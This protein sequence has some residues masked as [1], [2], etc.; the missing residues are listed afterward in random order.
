[1]A[2]DDKKFFMPPAVFAPGYFWFL[3]D[4]LD[5]DKLVAQLEDMAKSGARSVCPHPIPKEFRA[6][7]Y[8]TM[9]PAYLSKAFFR[10]MRLI[11]DTCERLKMNCYLY[12]EGGWPSG[13]ACGQVY[14]ANPEKFA[15]RYLVPD[16][17]GRYKILV[18]APDPAMS[19]PY[20]NLLTPG[21]TEKFLA[22]THQ[23]YFK[24]SPKHFGKTLCFTF[25][26]EPAGPQ[27][28]IDKLPWT[29]DFF[30]E[31]KKRKN[32]DVEPFIPEMLRFSCAP[33]IIAALT[34]Y[35]DVVSQ[36]FVERFLA[37][38][39]KWCNAHQM[40]SGGH[41]NGEDEPQNMLFHLHGNHLLRVLRQLDMPGVDVIWRQIYPGIRLHSFPKY[42]SSAANQTGNRHVLGEVFGV[43]GSGITPAEMK[44]LVDY[45]AL[46]GVNTFVFATYPF[47][48]CGD[49]IQGE[50][51][52]FG[53]CNL[54]WRRLKGFH[55]YT[56][57]ISYLAAAGNP[58]VD[59]A[60]FFDEATLSEIGVV[61]RYDEMENIAARLL[62]RQCDFDYIDEDQLLAAKVSRG[63]IKI[64]KAVYCRIVMPT[65]AK[66]TAKGRAALEKLQK[67][68]A[69]VFSS[70]QINEIP[71]TLLMAQ[72]DDRLRVRKRKLAGGDV[73]YM[74]MN[75]SSATLRVR[76]TASEKAPVAWCDAETGKRCL[77]GKAGVWQ[78]RFAPYENAVFLVGEAA[79]NAAKLPHRPGATLR[80]LAGKWQLKALRQT[81]VG[82]DDYENKKSNGSITTVSLGDWRNSLGND[83]SGEAQYVKTFDGKD[84][85]NAKFLDLGRVCYAA[86]VTLNGVDLGTRLSPPYVFPLGN[87]L[88]ATQNKLEITVVNTPANA[89]AATGV[90]EKW[91]QRPFENPYEMRERYF[92]RESLESGL[93]G[94]VV[95]KKSIRS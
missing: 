52:L 86:Q 26:D 14:A 25:T 94:P 10:K 23:Q 69:P 3:N 18:D 71:P 92:E 5:D 41:F 58:A 60:L 84:L 46:C 19:A 31:F 11:H 47:S 29:E 63:A 82:K 53:K 22:L 91:Q 48:T 95:F 15:R 38:L 88:K 73:L 21:V 43:Y 81:S 79:K 89:I 70:D 83:F 51:P 55:D 39:K 77:A 32:Y 8:S 7:F 67:K 28:R 12:D 64:G 50:R 80:A 20:P 85:A 6:S 2:F 4:K 40:L 36:L 1:M 54:L 37:P 74:V 44:F 33:Q 34:D 66:L 13:G 78:W 93:F 62:Q 30:T 17:Q 68:G 49:K 59:T 24:Y 35:S 76:F 42:A 65:A 75:I 27:H 90:L 45:L 57:R 9:E 72:T 16:G 61:P 56:A 87:A